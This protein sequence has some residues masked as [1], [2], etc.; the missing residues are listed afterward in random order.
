M[1]PRKRDISEADLDNSQSSMGSHNLRSGPVDPKRVRSNRWDESATANNGNPM[2]PNQPPQ[3]YPNGPASVVTK[4][5]HMPSGT[6]PNMNYQNG[7]H[8]PNGNGSYSN[9]F[10]NDLLASFKLAP[11]PPPPGPPSGGPPPP[12]SLMASPHAAYQGGYNKPSYY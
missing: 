8:H 4:P 2:M 3:R 11:P 12:M 6:P 5:P 7:G 1:M 10:G 9:G